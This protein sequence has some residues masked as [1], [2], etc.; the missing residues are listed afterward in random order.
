MTRIYKTNSKVEVTVDDITV[1]IS[2]LS[3]HQKMELQDLM[4]R[5]ASNDMDAAMK[6]VVKAL[7]MAIKEVKGLIVDDEG[8]EYKLEFNGEELSD[9]CVNDLL[10]I[11]CSNKLTALCTALLAGVPDKIIGPDGMPVP[12]ISFVKSKV[13]N[14]KPKK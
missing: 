11:P 1:F 6:A 9:E 10:N 13:E 7:K 2:P 4:L 3:Y 8:T 5:A 12:G 14:K